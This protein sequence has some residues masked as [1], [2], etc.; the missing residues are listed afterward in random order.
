MNNKLWCVAKNGLAE[1]YEVDI[2]KETPKTYMISSNGIKRRIYKDDSG[3]Y[4]EY[5]RY[6]IEEEKARKYYENI[7]WRQ[8]FS[9][10]RRR[11][12]YTYTEILSLPIWE[13]IIKKVGNCGTHVIVEFNSKNKPD[14]YALCIGAS[15]NRI[16]L[17]N[18]KSW[19]LTKENYIKACKICRR[20][21]LGEEE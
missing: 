19:K 9:N 10:I 15:N 3:G 21:F 4:H 20:L 14:N 8:G 18:Y 13:E 16:I 17:T 1:P 2:I 7:I 12:T 11:V 6:F 5:C